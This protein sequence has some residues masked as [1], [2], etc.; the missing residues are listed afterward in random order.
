MLA[1]LYDVHGNLAA[2]EAVID[3]AEAAG[4]TAWLVGGDVSAFGPWP[5]DALRRL[6]GLQDARW[7][8]GNHE[9][10][11]VE[12]ADVPDVP[13]AR[14]GV[15]AAR[16]ALGPA[17]VAELYATSPWQRVPGGE[18]WHAS[19]RSDVDGFGAEPSD[20][21]AGLLEQR[22]PDL[23]VVGHT[24]VQ[25]RR[26]VVRTDGG[27]TTV[28]NPGSVGLPFDGDPRAAYG[29]LDDDGAVELRRVEYDAERAVAEQAARWGDA[30]WARAVAETYRTG[31]PSSIT[32]RIE[33]PS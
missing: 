15:V 22:T 24:H 20:D 23:L 32:A 19:P 3:D 6:R 13:L 27:T 25:L 10:W 4:A 26:E 1:L 11:A 17:T 29:L 21:D 9:R 8:R 12:T 16:E 7:I 14:G 33:N 31:R 30:A 2:L 28:V 18:A 5:V